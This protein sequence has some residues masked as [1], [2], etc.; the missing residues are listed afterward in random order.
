[1]A[2]GS[3]AAHEPGDPQASSTSVTCCSEPSP[4]RLRTQQR[5]DKIKLYVLR[6]PEVEGNSKAQSQKPLRVRRDPHPA[7]RPTVSCLFNWKVSP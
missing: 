7:T 5:K 3:G 6:A 1:M 4:K 2:A